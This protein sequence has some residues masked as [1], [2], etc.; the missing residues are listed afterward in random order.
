MLEQAVQIYGRRIDAGE[1]QATSG[2][3]QAL[4]S[5]NE[6]QINYE[7]NFPSESNL[8]SAQEAG[9]EI[10]GDKINAFTNLKEYRQLKVF[11]G[12]QQTESDAK[13]IFSALVQEQLEFMAD[14]ARETLSPI[15]INPSID[16]LK[17]YFLGTSGMCLGS[18]LDIDLPEEEREVIEPIIMDV[19]ILSSAVNAESGEQSYQL[20]SPLWQISF[21]DPKDME[22]GFFFLEKYVIVEDKTEASNA[23]VVMGA[24]PEAI[25]NRTELTRGIT[26]F[27]DWQEFIDGLILDESVDT[28]VPLSEYFGN[29]SLDAGNNLQGS[30]GVRYGLRLSYAL[31]E[32]LSIAVKAADSNLNSSNI[33]AIRDRTYS[34]NLTSLS[35]AEISDSPDEK[36]DIVTSNLDLLLI[37]LV[38]TEVDALDMAIDSYASGDASAKDATSFISFYD[39]NC[40]AELLAKEPRLEL[41][42]EYVFPL[43]KLQGLL[44]IYTARGFVPS[45]GEDDGWESFDDRKDVGNLPFSAKFDKWDQS[46]TFNKSKEQCRRLFK[47]MWNSREFTFTDEDSHDIQTN[48]SENMRDYFG[49]LP[50]LDVSWFMRNR[51]RSNPFDKDGNEC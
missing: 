17:K 32:S 9:E 8:G 37:P 23:A 51:S 44:S 1:I 33:N 5:L 16:N 46:K 49:L 14:S 22:S 20:N 38:S 18:N 7:T 48:F 28:S 2:T 42:L 36:S 24:V 41:L 11:Q 4:N 50:N 27:E 45:I 3:Q 29:L 39:A 12:I 31:P 15:G 25:I 35:T 21:V 40:M 34:P 10:L 26:S 6:F 13:T 47:S 19:G 30:V 43:E